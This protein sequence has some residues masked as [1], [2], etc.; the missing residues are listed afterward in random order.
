VLGA[1]A[2]VLLPQAQ[3]KRGRNRGVLLLLVH[4]RRD[5]SAWADAR[6]FTERQRRCW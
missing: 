4:L 2:R 6:S 5:P 1:G 3:Q